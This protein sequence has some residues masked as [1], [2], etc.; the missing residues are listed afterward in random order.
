M[1]VWVAR[2]SV[3]LMQGGANLPDT[4]VTKQVVEDEGWFATVTSVA[5]GLMSLALLVLTVFLV[6][7]AYNI[8]KS[9][10]KIS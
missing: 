7:A 1:N 10:Q 6:P 3:W 2:A 4:I 8:R 5:S 9:Y